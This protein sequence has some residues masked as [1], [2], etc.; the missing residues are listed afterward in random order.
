MAL[1]PIRPAD[2]A[3]KAALR[4]RAQEDVFRREVDEAVRQDTVSGFSASGAS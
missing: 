1:S 2:P 3:D 4:Q